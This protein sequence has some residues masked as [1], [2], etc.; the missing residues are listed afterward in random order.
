M[1]L[2][3]LS[4]T[5]HEEKT[6][7]GSVKVERINHRKGA[8]L[9]GYTP[10]FLTRNVFRLFA[11]FFKW[12][13]KKQKVGWKDFPDGQGLNIET[14]TLSTH[15]GTHLD[16]P[17]HFGL[18]SNNQPAKK[19]D[20]IPLEWCY[21]DGVLVDLTWKGKA[22]TICA[23]D[24]QKALNEIDYR[25][26]PGDI[27]LINTGASKQA[28]SEYYLKFPGMSSEATEWLI[29]QGVKV[30]GIDT[31]GFDRPFLDMIEDYLID[32]NSDKLWPAHLVGRRK[33][34]CHIERLVNLDKIPLAFGFKVAC[35]PIK[36]EKVGASWVRA[37]AIL[38]D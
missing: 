34:Y 2:I 14:I 38:K 6:R 11:L 29:D 21:G 25:L 5:I 15:T 32:R 23:R 8:N 37:V 7:M 1:K 31:F 24:I 20:E 30:I 17:F 10:F 13:F 18:Y 33:E 9:L 12:I 26:K 27:V 3:D 22:G 28:G 4:V 19:I 36:V 16:A 35:F